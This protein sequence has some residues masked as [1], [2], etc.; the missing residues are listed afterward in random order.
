MGG[1]AGIVQLEEQGCCKPRVGGSSPPTG[2]WSSSVVVSTSG[3]QPEDGEFNSPL[4]CF[5][6]DLLIRSSR[7]PRVS[8]GIV[9]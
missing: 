9:R 5:G 1:F 2:S 6:A 3:F 8:R 7:R 4:D